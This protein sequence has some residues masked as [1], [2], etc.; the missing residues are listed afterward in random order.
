MRLPRTY[1]EPI[2]LA[3]NS[4]LPEWN[5][6]RLKAQLFQESQ[7]DPNAVSRAG[8]QGIAQFM[9]ATWTDV[10]ARM[11]F[12]QTASPFEPAYAIPAAAWYMDTLRRQ[13]SAPRPDADRWRLTLAAYNT[14]M[15]N[16]LRAQKAAGGANDFTTIMAY[17]PA[18]TGPGGSG[19]TRA[20]VTRIEGYYAQ[21]LAEDNP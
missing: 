5:W 13:W 21:L 14:G 8:A 3:V 9:P 11:G 4:Y 7:F 18:V 15:G 12:P 10:R 6:L 2:R 17:L 19:E 16:M 20:Y 1:D